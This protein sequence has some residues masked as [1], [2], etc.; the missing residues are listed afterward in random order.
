MD[1]NILIVED[2][3]II[4][5]S[6]QL[7]LESNGFRTAIATDPDEAGRLIKEQQFDL[8]LSDINLNHPTDGITFVSNNVAER[9][10]VV[11]L[12]AYSDLDTL[13][14]AELV[15]PYAYLI[16]PFH[17]DQLLLTI[18]LSIA[19]ARKKFLSTSISSFEDID[20]I[21]LSNREIEIVQLIAQGKTS[22]DIAKQLFISRDTVS[23]HRKNIIRKTGCKN[24]VELVALAM[25][26]GWLSD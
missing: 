8:I 6:I 14:K 10:P 16:K 26:R 15:M 7:H 13:N 3:I 21:V 25:E 19:H 1:P 17:K 5:K 9:V 18:N 12:T 20:E 24:I 4:A 22:A 2:E 23:T 11:F